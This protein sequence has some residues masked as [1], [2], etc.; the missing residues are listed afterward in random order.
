[1]PKSNIFYITLIELARGLFAPSRSSLPAHCYYLLRIYLFLDYFMNLFV[2]FHL[3]AY[4]NYS[5]PTSVI[6]QLSILFKSIFSLSVLAYTTILA[7]V[8]ILRYFSQFIFQNCWAAFDQFSFDIAPLSQYTRPIIL[9][10]ITHRT[11]NFQS[12]FIE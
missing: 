5:T 12:K 7:L 11:K 6:T 10:Q 3:L 2:Y 4:C 9:R 1:M 8:G